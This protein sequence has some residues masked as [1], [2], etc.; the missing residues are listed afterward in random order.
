MDSISYKY[1][2]SA[3]YLFV[4]K[5]G[6]LQNESLS[7]FAEQ[8]NM[9]DWFGGIDGRRKCSFDAISDY[10]FLSSR[11]KASWSA[12]DIIPESSKASR[13]G[14]DRITRKYD[15]LEVDF[16]LDDFC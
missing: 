1:E 6:L 7:A 12:K 13:K 4:L 10:N 2:W 8:M 15:N 3:V 16:K 5:H 11:H 9:P 14:V